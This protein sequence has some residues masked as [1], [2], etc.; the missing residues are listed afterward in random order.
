MTFFARLALAALAVF[1]LTLPAA[2]VD[3]GT[4]AWLISGQPLYE[5]PGHAYRV[6]GELGDETRIRVDRC[7]KLWCR[8]HARGQRGWVALHNISFGQ[9]PRGPLTGPHLNYPSGGSVCLYSGR[10]Y[11]G[12]ATCLPA[13]SVARDLLLYGTDN[14]IRSVEVHGSS[15][16]LCRDRDF[17]SYCTR[18]VKNTPRLNHFLDGQVSSYRVY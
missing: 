12:R 6:T 18:I 17:S 5:G 9:E 3:T 16:T 8:I 15:V 14:S 11:T 7:S 10:N 1:A 2:A 4:P 13:G